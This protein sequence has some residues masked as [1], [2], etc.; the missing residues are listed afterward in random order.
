[1]IGGLLGGILTSLAL[2]GRARRIVALVVYAA[3]GGAALTGILQGWFGILQGSYL[4]NASAVGLTLLA[5]GATVLG[6]ASVIGRPGLALGAV[7]FILFAVPL[8]SAATPVEFLPEPWGA[9][10]QWFPP[11]AGATLLR[12]LSYF[13]GADASFPW[14]VLAVWAVA[15]L[16]LA[17]VGRALDASPASRDAEVEP[18]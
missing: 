3:V 7:T 4:V 13:P 17:L 11:G 1:M 15:G 10:G 6:F 8:A 16:L 12:D 5:V 2:R 9:V 14:L 18:A